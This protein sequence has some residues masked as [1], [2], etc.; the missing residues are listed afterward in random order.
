MSEWIYPVEENKDYR[1]DRGYALSAYAEAMY[2]T[3][4]LHQQ[5]RF[6][7]ATC[8]SI[9]EKL[10]LAFLWGACYNLPG[11]F[12][13]MQKFPTPPDGVSGMRKFASWYNE[14]FDDYRVDVDCRYRKSK[15]IECVG[16]YVGWL[17][18]RTQEEALPPSFQSLWD[19]SMRWAFF[20]RLAVWNYVEGVLVVLNEE[21][22]DAPDF[23]LRDIR[24][25]ESNRN[26]VAYAVHRTD[27]VTKHGKKG[28]GKVI[29]MRE[30]ELLEYEA[31]KI[32]TK[33]KED[34]GHRTLVS[35][36][37]VETV[38]CWSKKLMSRITNS[39]YLGWDGDRTYEEMVYLEGLGYDLSGVREA[40]KADLPD[41][42]RYNTVSKEK[43]KAFYQQGTMPEIAKHQRLTT[44]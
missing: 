40:Y 15:M 25:S 39:R 24:G 6:M 5:L 37:N 44:P 19:T 2:S 33:A 20:G 23:L 8:S 4:E 7:D 12:M 38:F 34:F 17:N 26:G 16:S 11:P 32:F 43:M 41:H 1:D 42:L 18:G 31:D 27:L 10:W 9:E 36:M 29:T 30:C 14:I 22:Y 21:K 3:K 28:N 35:R 13:V